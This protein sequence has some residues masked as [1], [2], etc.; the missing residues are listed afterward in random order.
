MQGCLHGS[1]GSFSFTDQSGKS[2]SL[3]GNTDE[4]KGHNGQTVEISGSPQGDTFAVASVSKVAD[5]CQDRSPSMSDIPGHSQNPVAALTKPEQAAAQ[6]SNA[7]AGPTAS[8]SQGNQPASG[9]QGA[10]PAGEAAQLPQTASPWPFI[11]LLGAG[12]VAAGYLS[13]RWK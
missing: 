7:S 2:W 8:Q 10:A 4:L 9:S 5:S 3:T 6:G 1:E 11:G 12:S 13:R